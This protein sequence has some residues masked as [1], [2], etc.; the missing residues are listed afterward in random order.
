M[1]LNIWAFIALTMI[2]SV[3]CHQSGTAG[4]AAVPAPAPESAGQPAET[5]TFPISRG[6]I[7]SDNEIPVYSRIQGQLLDVSLLEGQKVSK[8]QVLF[9]LDDME[10]RADVELCEAELEQSRLRMDEI[11]IEQ[12][13]KHKDFSQVPA[14]VIEYAKI[15]SGYTRNEKELEIV[16]VKLQR[17]VITAP[18]SGVLTSLK[19]GPY[20][21]VEPGMTLCT[22]VDT[23]KLKVDFSVL[24]TELRRY[25]AGDVITVC[26][27]SF[28]EETY[29]AVISTTGSIVNGDGMVEIEAELKENGKLMP[30]MTA[31]INTK[32]DK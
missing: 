31:L 6:I 30:G 17:S 20:Y 3:S 16:K 14:Q 28:P 4:T 26:P 24:E 29:D 15:K 10:L 13:Y 5:R 8:G 27:I 9:R 2:I 25:Q 22:V 18:I 21:F 1:K 32:S 11:L 19:V 7:R 12:G 23:K